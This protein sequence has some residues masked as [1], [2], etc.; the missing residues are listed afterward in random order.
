[1]KFKLL[2][3]SMFAIGVA[4]SAFAQ[5]TS[6]TPAQQNGAYQIDDAAN[7]GSAPRY[8]SDVVGDGNGTHPVPMP[9]VDRNITYSVDPSHVMECP[10]MAQQ[11]SGVDTRG[12]Q[13]GASISDS[14]REHDN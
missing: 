7:G 10:G 12:G 1:M 13:S 8:S 9:D 2:A 5:S 6:V 14:C 4:T 11:N 3:T